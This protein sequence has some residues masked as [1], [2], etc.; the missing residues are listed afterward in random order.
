MKSIL[1]F[2]REALAAERTKKKINKKP[3]H[4]NV[5]DDSSD[6]LNLEPP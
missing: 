6:V 3:V 1:S 2:S 4:T 5:I